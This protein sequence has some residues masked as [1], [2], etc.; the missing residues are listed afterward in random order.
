VV[1]FGL[2]TLKISLA[3]FAAFEPIF[4]DAKHCTF[5]VQVDLEATLELFKVSLDHENRFR[6]EGGN[7]SGEGLP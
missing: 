2:N 4:L 6:G 7:L 5:R 3:D 1:Y